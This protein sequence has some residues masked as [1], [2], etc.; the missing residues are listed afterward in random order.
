M[1]FSPAFARAAAGRVLRDTKGDT[2]I[3]I[4]VDRI[5]HLENPI[6]Y[7]IM[8]I[9]VFDGIHIGHRQILKTI[10]DRARQ[11]GGKAILLTFVPHPQKVIAG[12]DSPP[13]L[14]TLAQ[15]EELL[16]QIGIDVLVTTPFDR[17]L[18]LLSPERFVQ[19]FLYNHGIREIYVGSNFRF[20]HRRGG[21]FQMLQEFGKELGFRVR[22]I[23]PVFFRGRRVSSTWVRTCV[24]EGRLALAGRLLARPY[25]V[26]G[27]VA[28]GAGRGMEFG[29]P[30][31]NLEV[32]N[33]LIPANGVYATRVQVDGRK[34]PSVTN[35]GYRPTLYRQQDKPVV[36]THILDFEGEL[37]GKSLRLEFCLRLRAERK[38]ESLQALRRQ[39]ERD[40]G[41]TRRYISRMRL[42]RGEE[43][44]WP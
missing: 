39:I 10:V 15:K 17:G 40:V 29:F 31:A 11:V 34:R 20:G 23:T 6:S 38:F 5:S 33:E 37:Y 7:P 42:R 44:T 21:D 4:I 24:R 1:P 22:D 13:L 2:I 43:I 27:M 25:Q 12:G 19:D 16:E 35:I 18:S 41:T 32:D 36:E 26:C 3:M 14:Q 30:T 9:G 28:R 8:T